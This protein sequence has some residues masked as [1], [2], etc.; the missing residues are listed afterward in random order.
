MSFMK[1]K[2]KQPKPRDEVMRYHLA[3]RFNCGSHRS[4]KDYNRK[5]KSWKQE[6]S[7]FLFINVRRVLPCFWATTLLLEG[8]PAERQ[9]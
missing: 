7:D 8:I 3:N 6:P 9:Q 4:K 2:I 1:T 5:D